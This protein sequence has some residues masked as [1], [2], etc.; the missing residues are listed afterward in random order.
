MGA[1]REKD[2]ADFDLERFVDMFDEAMSSN[3]PRVLDALRSLMM[4]VTLTRPE[5]RNPASE[6][7]SG[8]LRRLFE[9]MN[10]LNNRLHRME[11]DLNKVARDQQRA[12]PRREEYRWEDQ[13]RYAKV[14]AAQMA[15]IIDND[16]LLEQGG[17]ARAHQTAHDI[18]TTPRRKRHNH[19]N[20]ALG[21]SAMRERCC[22]KYNNADNRSCMH[23]VLLPTRTPI[24]PASTASVPATQTRCGNQSPP[25][26]PKPSPARRPF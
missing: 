18:G 7:Q 2:Q 6:R 23:H 4:I 24:K 8:P 13:E 16:V 17:H 26:G 19:A 9:D 1:A 12:W 21:I 11:E 10:H 5:S 14:A 20:G 22:E 3:D 25:A 15:Q